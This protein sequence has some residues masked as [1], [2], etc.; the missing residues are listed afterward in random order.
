M[1]TAATA[2]VVQKDDF[3]AKQ[4]ISSSI[5]PSSATAGSPQITLTVKG[6]KFIRESQVLWNGAARQTVFDSATQLRATIP[7]ADLANATTVS[8]AVSNPAPGGG[9]SAPLSFVINP[10]P[11]SDAEQEPNE[12]SAQATPLAFPGKRMGQAA[13]GDAFYWRINYS[14]GQVDGLEDFFA[15][16]LT[17]SAAVD[18]KL[19]AA[20]SSADLDL[21]LFKEENGR[22]SYLGYSIYGPGVNERIITQRPLAPGRY[23]VAVSA[24]RG[25]SAYTL[26]ADAP[27]PRLLYL[28]FN[29]TL[30]GVNGETPLMP[31]RG[32]YTQGVAGSGFSITSGS[33]LVYSN[34]NNI[35]ASE[36]TVELWVKP[37]W[38][39]N[40]SRHHYILRHGGA[41]GILIGK[42]SANNLRLILN[43]YGAAGGA[44]V[45]TGFSVADWQANRWYHVAFIWSNRERVIRLYVNGQLK[46]SRTFTQSLP[47]ISDPRLQIGGDGLGRY[48]EA[49]IDELSIYGNALSAQE[50]AARYNTP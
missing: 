32:A 4:E 21:F 13:V 12:N 46:S 37:A 42:D 18:L 1:R 7:A 3:P 45:D 30:N 29:N 15:L 25:S 31:T 28:S 14:G 2:A 27:D 47:A 23:L 44:E 24:F 39:G 34:E 35:N 5:A 19:V 49:V 50:I 33:Y 38:N 36:G 48:L 20:N 40:D 43:R 16:T 8:V 11:N 6:D 22:L 10:R 26:T 41:G 17:Q 9:V